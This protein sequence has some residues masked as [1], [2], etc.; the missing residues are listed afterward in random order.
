MGDF[1]DRVAPGKSID[2]SLSRF[3]FLRRNHPQFSQAAI[4]SLFIIYL[5]AITGK[6]YNINLRRPQ[7]SI[8]INY[9]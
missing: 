3:P 5:K 9:E 8:E 4:A 2:S 7:P 6:Q 1:G